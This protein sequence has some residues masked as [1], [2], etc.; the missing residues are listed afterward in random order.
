MYKFRQVIEFGFVSVQTRREVLKK[1]IRYVLMA[2]LMLAAFAFQPNKAMALDKVDFAF[3]Y[4]TIEDTVQINEDIQDNDS[5]WTKIKKTAKKG[6]NA[7]KRGWEKGVTRNFA[8]GEGEKLWYSEKDPNMAYKVKRVKVTTEEELLAAMGVSSES[9]LSN[10]QKALLAVFRTAYSDAIQ[11]K[12][13]DSILPR[14]NVILTD[15]TNFTNS[16]LRD[17]VKKDFWPYSSF[18]TINM[19]NF[20]YD[21][22][23]GDKDAT[24]T[25][26]HEYAH[27]MDLTVKEF[28]DPY[29][30]DG[31]HYGNEVTSKRAAFVEAWAEYNE[32]I[33]SEDEAKN[34]IKNTKKL[35]VESK[36]K[37]GDYT[38]LDP[39]E[40]TSEQLKAAES[41]NAYLLYRL[42][43]EID[44]GKEKVTKAFIGTRWKL[45]RDLS[46][47]VKRFIKN[48]P[49]DAK[50]VCEIVDEVFLGKF[51]DEEMF[52]MC[53]KSQAVKDYIATR[54]Q[55]VEEVKEEE[56]KIES[57]VAEKEID[58][59]ADED[60]PFAVR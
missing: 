18:F 47:L 5:L 32:M 20:F 39:E 9:E 27:C 30:K 17:A 45:F 29:G 58:S 44:G 4:Q 43:T 34:I 46:T 56:T 14:V 31:S 59:D 7:V 19:S 15:T 26:I 50:K 52:D 10:G 55:T 24:S 35:W 1:S 54:G 40:A 49:D 8:L 53:G 25:M 23:G 2:L 21:Y 48:N 11:S 6:I 3:Y 42:A 36:D 41:Y 22:P 38:D 51:T 37:A 57:K 28:K 33:E 16:E 13:K 12:A 60:S